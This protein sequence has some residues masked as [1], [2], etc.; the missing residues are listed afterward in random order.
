MAWVGRGGGGGRDMLEI[1][2]RNKNYKK[3]ENLL[4]LKK[5]II[6]KFVIMTYNTSYY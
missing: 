3:L 4:S 6:L 2:P 1:E 5:T